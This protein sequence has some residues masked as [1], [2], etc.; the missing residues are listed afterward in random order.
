ME[1]K[2]FYLKDEDTVRIVV[3]DKEGIDNAVLKR[4]FEA[5]KGQNNGFKTV[6]LKITDVRFTGEDQD[7]KGI[8]FE[9]E[10]SK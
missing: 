9:I 5:S 3:L 7:V 2:D 1:I 10:L 6:R 8:G 4:L